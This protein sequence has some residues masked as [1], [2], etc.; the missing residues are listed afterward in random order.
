MSGCE[1][2]VAKAQQHGTA[3]QV[4]CL[5]Q[6]LAADQPTG[7]HSFVWLS[8]CAK[9]LCLVH[10]SPLWHWDTKCYLLEV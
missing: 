9:A 8:I 3:V 7:M 10:V 1:E 5:A 6:V 2:L 4:G